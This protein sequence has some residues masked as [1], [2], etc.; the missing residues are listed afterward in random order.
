MMVKWL[1]FL[2]VVWDIILGFLGEYE[3]KSNH[4]MIVAKNWWKKRDGLI[5][6]QPVQWLD[7]PDV[8]MDNLHKYIGEYNWKLYNLSSVSKNWW[9]TDDHG[10]SKYELGT[11]LLEPM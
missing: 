6:Y 4:L 9:K 10:V 3:W 7:L 11:I 8:A 2:Y 1:N 5:H